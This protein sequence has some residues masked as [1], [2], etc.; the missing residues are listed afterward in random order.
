MYQTL[1]RLSINF[2]GCCH[3]FLLGSLLLTTSVAAGAA[4]GDLANTGVAGIDPSTLSM[5]ERR[6][7]L[8]RL[9]DAEVRVLVQQM[10]FTA[11]EPLVQEDPGVVGDLTMAGEQIR[12]E[13]RR[14]LSAA[15]ELPGVVPGIFRSMIPENAD[16]GRVMVVLF[17]I[18]LVVVGGLSAQYFL[19]R[20]TVAWVKRWERESRDYLSR[21]GYAL[22]RLILQLV[23]VAG[24]VAAASAVFLV[25]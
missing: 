19:R 5:E 6:D 24:F 3:V 1:R 15:P 11:S 14:W 25:F 8:G 10:M 18:V 21:F 22:L 2:K 7:L 17:L 20:Y 13:V 4:E 16:T 23:E 12:S 9:T